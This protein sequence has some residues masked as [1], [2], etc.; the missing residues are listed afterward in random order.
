[1]TMGP[2]PS[3]TP[4]SG[5]QPSPPPPDYC[6]PAGFCRDFDAIDVIDDTV[7]AFKGAVKE[8]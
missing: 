4:R 3:T 2:R 7:Y 6:P 1:V 5:T 8:L